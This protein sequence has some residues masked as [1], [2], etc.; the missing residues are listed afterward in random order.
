MRFIDKFIR[1][2][3]SSN[4]NDNSALLYNSPAPLRQNTPPDEFD[5][6]VAEGFIAHQD[7]PELCAVATPEHSVKTNVKFLAKKAGSKS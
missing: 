5:V 7:V 6:D 3:Q 4:Q 2:L 1:R